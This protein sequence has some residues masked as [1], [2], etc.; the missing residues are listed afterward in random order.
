M[1][2]DLMIVFLS[3][4]LLLLF[5]LQVVVVQ[6]QSPSPS[7]SP[8]QSQEQV[9]TPRPTI[10]IPDEPSLTFTIRKL[11]RHPRRGVRDL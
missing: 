5:F 6:L 8:L 3:L 1:M 11:R 4:L 10:R 2:N 7:P 9:V